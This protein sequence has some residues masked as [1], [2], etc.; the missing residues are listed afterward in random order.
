M[1]FSCS[2]DDGGSNNSTTELKRIVS[3]Y[4]YNGNTTDI[5]S[6]NYDG[7][8][9]YLDTLFASNKTAHWN[10]NSAGLLSSYTESTFDNNETYRCDFQYNS[11]DEIT[12]YNEISEDGTSYNTIVN[13]NQN[14][15]NLIKSSYSGFHLETTFTTNSSGLFDSKSTSQG[16]NVNNLEFEGNNLLKNKRIFVAESA[17]STPV[18]NYIEEIY[19]I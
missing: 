6:M 19:Y 8:R 15:I 18:L 7:G 4:I 10:Y 9:R 2:D 16:V 12:S 11:S 3:S 13:Y 14:E 5:I 17:N 1:F